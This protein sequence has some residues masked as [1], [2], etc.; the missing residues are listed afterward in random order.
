M[1]S[2]K[3]KMIADTTVAASRPRICEEPQSYSVP[4]QENASRSGTIV[5]V[6]NREPR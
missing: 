1:L 5:V 3:I 4:A 2:M 6:I